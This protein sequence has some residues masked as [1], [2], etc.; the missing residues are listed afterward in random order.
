MVDPIENRYKDEEARL[1]ATRDLEKC[2]G[3]YRT[4]VNSL[5]PMDRESV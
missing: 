3:D 5:P 4:A 1:Q 2:I